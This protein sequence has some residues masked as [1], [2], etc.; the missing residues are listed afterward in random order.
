MANR[1]NSHAEVANGRD[2]CARGARR[3]RASPL[4]HNAARAALTNEQLAHTERSS[5]QSS[6]S[7][8]RAQGGPRA[9]PKHKGKRTRVAITGCCSS[10]IPLQ[11]QREAS[12]AYG[13]GKNA[14]AM[15]AHG[16]GKCAQRDQTRARS[17]LHHDAQEQLLRT[18]S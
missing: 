17:S 16:R 6:E 10:V 11:A 4:R 18:S 5:A 15:V 14:H 1:Q 7:N 2:K 9:H 12:R 13:R 3:E 8:G